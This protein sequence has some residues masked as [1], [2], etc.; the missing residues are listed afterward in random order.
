M[1]CRFDDSLKLCISLAYLTV[2]YRYVIVQKVYL[3][4][5]ALSSSSGRHTNRFSVATGE[6]TL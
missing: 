4:R 3:Q 6:K 2:C 1:L 5:A